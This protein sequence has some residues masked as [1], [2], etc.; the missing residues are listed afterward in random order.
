MINTRMIEPIMYQKFLLWISADVGVGVGVEESVVLDM[1]C[2]SLL[3][4]LFSDG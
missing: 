4:I 3:K 1:K 2:Y